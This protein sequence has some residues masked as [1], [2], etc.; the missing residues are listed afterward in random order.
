[1]SNL[2]FDQSVYVNIGIADG[3]VVRAPT[4]L[5]TTG[6]GSCVGLV[7]YDESSSVAGMVHVM[8]P[9]APNSPSINVKKYADRAIP[10]LVEQMEKQGAKVNRLCAKL[11]GGAQMFNFPGRTDMIRVGPRNVEAVH[12]ALTAYR[13][14]IVSEDTGGNVGRTIQFDPQSSVL[15][16][17]TAKAGVYTI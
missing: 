11:A 17:R 3:D 12:Q 5:R 16:I 8:L 1:M 7:L 14:P 15:T 6:L 2:T 4:Q 13:L 10:W 9:E